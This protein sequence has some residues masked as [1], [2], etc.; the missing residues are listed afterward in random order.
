MKYT[1]GVQ[2]F[3]FEFQMSKKKYSIYVDVGPTAVSFFVITIL[4]S[5]MATTLYNGSIEEYSSCR[6]SQEKSISPFS[7][8]TINVSEFLVNADCRQVHPMKGSRVQ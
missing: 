4:G 5:V 1:T 6:F 8:Q 2:S 7:Q 3:K